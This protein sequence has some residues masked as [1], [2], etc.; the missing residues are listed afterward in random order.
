MLFHLHSSRK[1]PE[2]SKK[3][4]KKSQPPVSSDLHVVM[5][6]AEELKGLLV[7]GS[8]TGILY[9]EEWLHG[10]WL[11]ARH[12]EAWSSSTACVS[13]KKAG[14][15]GHRLQAKDCHGWLLGG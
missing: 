11:T 12:L 6:V 9:N 13:G 10:H 4:K 5:G 3:K 14:R 7:M 15:K 2:T 1:K 8:G